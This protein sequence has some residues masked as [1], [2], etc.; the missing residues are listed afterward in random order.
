LGHQLKA[1]KR[2]KRQPV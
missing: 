1:T 2:N